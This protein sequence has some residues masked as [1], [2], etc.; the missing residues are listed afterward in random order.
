MAIQMTPFSYDTHIFKITSPLILPTFSGNIS[1]TLLQARK[2]IFF[3]ENANQRGFIFL[4]EL[5]LSPAYTD[6]KAFFFSVFSIFFF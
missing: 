1:D 5:A 2:S 6:K 3:K 4:H